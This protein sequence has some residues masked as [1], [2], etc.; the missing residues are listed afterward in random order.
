MAGD[1]WGLPCASGGVGGGLTLT[2][3][4]ARYERRFDGIVKFFQ[5]G[6]TYHTVANH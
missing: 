2:I 1:L 5:F 6:A 4:L 3:K